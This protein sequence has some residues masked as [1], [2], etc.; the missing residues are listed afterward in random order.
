MKQTTITA[1]NDFLT[2]CG[3]F[4]LATADGAQP[5]ARPLGLH[6]DMDGRLLFTVGD[7]KEV[8]RQLK[9]NPLI[10]IVAINKQNDWLRLT[11]KAV[12][13]SAEDEARYEALCLAEA[14]YLK[15]EYNEETGHK[16]AFFHV[17]EAKAVIYGLDGSAR[18]L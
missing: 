7:F 3:V 11:G 12:E 15:A 6:L 16:M 1:V 4:W 13:E 14:P 17:T 10:E 2:E 18:E 8:Y 5:K 9:A